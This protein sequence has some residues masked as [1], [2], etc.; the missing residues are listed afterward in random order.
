MLF[1][2]HFIIHHPS[3]S[4]GI[5]ILET[6]ILAIRRTSIIID[7]KIHEITLVII[8]VSRSNQGSPTYSTFTTVCPSRTRVRH[9][10]SG[11]TDIRRYESSGNPINFIGNRLTQFPVNSQGYHMFLRKNIIIIQ[12]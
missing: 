6:T 8:I 4:H 2:E 3:R 11:M 10:H 12:H 5:E 9:R 1:H 7:R